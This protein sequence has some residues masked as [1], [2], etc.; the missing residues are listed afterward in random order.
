MVVACG[1]KCDRSARLALFGS[2]RV[3]PIAQESR[4]ATVRIESTPGYLSL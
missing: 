2:D 3:M 1:V 4:A